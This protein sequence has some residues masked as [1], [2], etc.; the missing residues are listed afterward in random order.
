[1]YTPQLYAR[2]SLGSPVLYTDQSQAPLHGLQVGHEEGTMMRIQITQML[3][4]L[5]V[6]RQLTCI[7]T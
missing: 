4:V 7:S 1:M 3:A 6:R 5:G 2:A